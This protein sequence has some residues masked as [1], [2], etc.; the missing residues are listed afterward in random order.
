MR[1]LGMQWG[2]GVAGGQHGAVDFEDK[3]NRT[4]NAAQQ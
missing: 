2:L 3:T 4:E 1:A